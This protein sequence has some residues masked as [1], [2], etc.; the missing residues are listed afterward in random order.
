MVG[1]V[2]CSPCFP[3]LQYFEYS[4][5]HEVRHNIQKEL[6]LHGAG[7]AVKLE[8]CQYKGSSTLVGVEQKW[9]LKDVSFGFFC[10]M[11]C[12]YIFFLSFFFWRKL[13]LFSPHLIEPAALHPRLEHV[14]ERPARAPLSG[15]LQPLRQIPA[16]VLCLSPA[17]CHLPPE[18][19]RLCAQ[20]C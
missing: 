14:P 2:L 5:H 3:V 8:D 9:E 18:I 13:K 17:N 6:C 1:S 15:P 19:A 12:Y 10:A 16:L 20:A 11:I 4:T 7:G